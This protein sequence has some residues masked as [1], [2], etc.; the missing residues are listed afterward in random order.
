MLI[1]RKLTDK[2]TI[3]CIQ[4][5]LCEHPKFALFKEHITLQEC[6]DLL[7]KSLTFSQSIGISIKFLLI[8]RKLRDKKQYDVHIVN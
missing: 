1:H 8:N 5:Q 6:R 4:L 7:E 3:Q 2:F